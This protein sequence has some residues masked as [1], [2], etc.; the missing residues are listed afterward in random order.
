[1]CFFFLSLLFANFS[2]CVFFSLHL[3]FF[4]V[5]LSCFCT[6]FCCCLSICP[7]AHSLL[8]SYWIVAQLPPCKVFAV[9]SHPAWP[10]L[11]F[12]PSE[13]SPLNWCRGHKCMAIYHRAKLC[14]SLIIGNQLFDILSLFQRNVRSILSCSW[15]WN[16]SCIMLSFPHTCANTTV[17]R[18]RGRFKHTVEVTCGNNITELWHP[19][20]CLYGADKQLY[21]SLSGCFGGVGGG[22]GAMLREGKGMGM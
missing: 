10:L 17:A 15:V 13:T 22:R 19:L 3:F 18:L 12:L 21:P 14:F 6:C 16:V 1:M 2:S 20:C 4:L 9:R 7:V 8:Y 11:L 5:C